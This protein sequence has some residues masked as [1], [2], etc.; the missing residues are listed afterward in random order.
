MK[1]K[2]HGLIKTKFLIL[3][4]AAQPDVPKLSFGLYEIYDPKGSAL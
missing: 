2:D 1:S 3:E 4:R